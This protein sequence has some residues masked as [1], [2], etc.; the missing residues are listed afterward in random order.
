VKQ[1]KGLQN[2]KQQRHAEF[3]DL[4]AQKQSLM[5]TVIAR[6]E[7]LDKTA[8][9]HRVKEDAMKCQLSELQKYILSLSTLFFI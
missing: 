4:D 9:Q 3:V 1:I 5:R 8:L 7:K 2:E 6:Q